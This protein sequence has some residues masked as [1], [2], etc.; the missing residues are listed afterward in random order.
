MTAAQP[1]AIYARVNTSDQGPA[2]QVALREY[3]AWAQVLG[4]LADA[5]GEEVA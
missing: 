3:T 4:L 5:R 2:M 1:A